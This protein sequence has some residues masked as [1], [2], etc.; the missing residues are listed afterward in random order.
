MLR[1][2]RSCNPVDRLGLRGGPGKW[3]LLTSFSGLNEFTYGMHLVVHT[4]QIPSQVTLPSQQND[5]QH[6]TDDGTD[7][8][9]GGDEKDKQV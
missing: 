4:L 9:G 6:K 5:D 2:C 1:C 7:Y 3:M 8:K